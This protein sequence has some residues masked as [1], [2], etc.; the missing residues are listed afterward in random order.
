MTGV[1]TLHEW[2]A[3][4]AHEYQSYRDLFPASAE[5][6][7]RCLLYQVNG[8]GPTHSGYRVFI[9]QGGWSVDVVE[10]CRIVAMTSA[11]SEWLDMM[12]RKL[13]AEID[14][15]MEGGVVDLILSD[16]AALP[17][18]EGTKPAVTGG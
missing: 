5:V 14:E 11:H 2:N 3:L 6:E 18:V 9:R 15:I 10:A 12:T 7:V 13:D 17:E 8:E 1:T 16:A 4:Q